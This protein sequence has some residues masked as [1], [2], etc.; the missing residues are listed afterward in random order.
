MDKRETWKRNLIRMRRCTL[1][2][3]E[4][5]IGWVAMLD[6]RDAQQTHSFSRDT[7]AKR[8]AQTEKRKKGGDTEW[9]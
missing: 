1:E 5:K 9:E 7:H 8:E 4:A 6:D 2:D 3:C